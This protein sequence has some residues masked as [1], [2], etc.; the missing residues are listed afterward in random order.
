MQ[1]DVAPAIEG[2]LSNLMLTPTQKGEM[3]LKSDEELREL[4]KD[5]DL[6]IK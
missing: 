5:L 4:K 6:D 3:L 1:V 2:E